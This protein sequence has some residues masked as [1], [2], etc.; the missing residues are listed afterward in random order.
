[1]TDEVPTPFMEASLQS[2]GVPALTQWSRPFSFDSFWVIESHPQSLYFRHLELKLFPIFL[3]FFLF[4]ISLWFWW[5]RVLPDLPLTFFWSVV[6]LISWVIAIGLMLLTYL[7]DPGYLPFFFPATNRQEFTFDE[8]RSGTAVT[9]LQRSWAR[10]QRRPGRIQFGERIGRFVIR[11]DHFC[12]FMGNWIGL[13][14]HRYFILS[15]AYFILY[16]TLYIGHLIYLRSHGNLHLVGWRLIS[17]IGEA[18]LFYPVLIEN[19]IRQIC[20]VTRNRAFVDVLRQIPSNW[21]RGC[22][23]NWEEVCGSKKFLPL[24]WLPVPL[25]QMIDGF[26]YEEMIPDIEDVDFFREVVELR[27]PEPLKEL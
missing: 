12:E 23:N 16:F 1:M 7:T 2:K 9:S 5:F 18:V 6:M 19:F 27:E 15:L 20:G 24:W 10:K 3:E 26:E 21:D 14:N 25:P 8:L 4:G 22:L 17:L 11:G 13:K